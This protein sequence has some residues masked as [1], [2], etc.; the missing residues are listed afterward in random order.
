MSLAG[1]DALGYVRD[2][3]TKR[4][5]ERMARHLTRP[6]KRPFERT[7]SAGRSR[8]LVRPIKI[9]AILTIAVLRVGCA[10]TQLS[11]DLK[12]EQIRVVVAFYNWF[13]LPEDVP[14]W[15]ELAAEVHG[16]ARPSRM[17]THYFVKIFKADPP[18]ALLSALSREGAVFLPGSQFSRG[19]GLLFYVEKI[20]FR[21][22]TRVVLV[23]GHWFHELGARS[24]TYEL[25]KEEGGWKVV[26][27][28]DESIS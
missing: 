2:P 16:V 27:T 26:M 12:A 10:S 20:E 4:D 11:E 15:G 21:S 1:S 25:A 6:Y 23:G 13:Y 9:L 18:P 22:P 7:G 14:R 3:R 19:R 8:L 28:I 5:L 24:G 17:E